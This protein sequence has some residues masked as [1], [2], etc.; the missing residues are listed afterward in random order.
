M[1]K[2]KNIRISNNSKTFIIAEACENHL[3]SMKK[4]FKMIDKSKECGADAVKFQHHIPD[5]EML[6]KVPKS[7]NFKKNLYEFLKKNSLKINQ[8]IELKKYC[9]KK[10]IIY[11]CTPFSYIAASEINSL[12]PFFKIGSGELLDH[13]TLIKISK[14]NKPMILSTG[15]ST[16][17]EITETYNILKNSNKLIL[18]HCVSEY[19]PVYKD[20]NIGYI[21]TMKK[22]FPKAIIGYSDHT[23]EIYSS[24]VAVAYG[25]KVIEKHVTL[26]QSIDCP[27]RDVSIN[28]DQLKELVLSIRK[29]ENSLGS[30]KK[31]HKL[32]KPIRDWAHRSVV[33][34]DKIKKGEKFTT[35]NLATKRPGTGIAAKSLKNILGKKSNKSL[36]NDYLLSY[37][38]I[39]S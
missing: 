34:I 26:D 1:I 7:K 31:I 20:L 23:N 16:E 36:N 18:M 8:H 12:V 25:S 38:D 21:K 35:K 5:E 37:K 32:E 6:K 3:G 29:I 4:A 30:E 13:P 39:V 33:T 10:K 9:D 14:F 2:I 19:P 22:K 15:M 17:K 24:L 11:L 27:D 28:F